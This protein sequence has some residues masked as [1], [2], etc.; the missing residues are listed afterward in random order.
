[1]GDL[2]GRA[3]QARGVAQRAGRLGDRHPQP[4][5]VRLALRREVEQPP[6]RLIERLL[7]VAEARRIA[8]LLDRVEDAARAIPRLALGF[9]E[10]RPERHV[11]SRRAA[12]LGSARLELGDALRGRR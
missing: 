3:D 1:A 4:L 8:G 10:D 9:R 6:R 2:L 11:V 7:A 5:V 12:E